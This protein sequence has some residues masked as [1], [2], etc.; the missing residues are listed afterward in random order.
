LFK[1]LEVAYFKVYFQNKQ[2]KIIG[3]DEI[4]WKI[5]LIDGI[6]V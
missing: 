5:I 2:L 3:E 1:A 4:G 6:V